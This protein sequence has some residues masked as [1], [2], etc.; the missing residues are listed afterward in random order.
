MAVSLAG[1]PVDASPL[2]TTMP[3]KVPK[4][5][6]GK[7]RNKLGHFKYKYFKICRVHFKIKK[8][9]KNRD[10]VFFKLLLLFSSASPFA[11]AKNALQRYGF[12]L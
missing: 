9:K 11:I 5:C 2:L 7:N 8:V 6:T 1:V 12:N 4:T 10:L 3:T